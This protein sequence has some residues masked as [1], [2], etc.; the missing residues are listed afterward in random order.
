MYV[1]WAVFFAVS[2]GAGLAAGSGEVG[3][4]AGWRRV[5]CGLSRARGSSGG[6]RSHQKLRRPTPRRPTPRIVRSAFGACATPRR[7]G[8]ELQARGCR[9]GAAE[10]RRADA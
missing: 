8:R 5:W 6:T 1:F 3:V 10:E 9:A 2:V 4:G 7:A